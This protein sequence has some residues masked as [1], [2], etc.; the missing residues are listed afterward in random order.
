MVMLGIP[1]PYEF[2]RE[3]L[4]PRPLKGQPKS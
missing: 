3:E 4:E 1:F 2:F